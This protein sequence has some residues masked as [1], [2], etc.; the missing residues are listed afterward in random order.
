M[1]KAIKKT[2]PA[3]A[4]G[5]QKAPEPPETLVRRVVKTIQGGPPGG[6]KLKTD[7]KEMER[8]RN[9]TPERGVR[10]NKMVAG[11]FAPPLQISTFTS[12]STSCSIY[13]T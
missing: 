13:D 8:T 4:Q 12:L 7:S 2:L 10:T 1:K 5:P 11:L 3:K 9:L 6:S